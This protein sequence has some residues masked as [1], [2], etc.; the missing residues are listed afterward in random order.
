MEGT[1]GEVGGNGA[2]VFSA[3]GFTS[4]G[5]AGMKGEDELDATVEPVTNDSVTNCI[6]SADSISSSRLL[7]VERSDGQF[8]RP[9]RAL[10]I[11][12]WVGVPMATKTWIGRVAR[13]RVK[14]FDRTSFAPHE[15][16]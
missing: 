2:T 16:K 8:R 10:R 4:A 9:G 11:R 12:S 3:T 7:Q 6:H 15:H 14:L 13:V 1:V 5:D